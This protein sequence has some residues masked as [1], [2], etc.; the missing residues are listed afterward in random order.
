MLDAVRDDTLKVRELFAM[1]RPILTNAYAARPHVESYQGPKN[2]KMAAGSAAVNSFGAAYAVG[3]VY[4]FLLFSHATEF[5]D[6]SGRLH[7]VVLTAAAALIAA[8]SA[9]QLPAT[10][11]SKPG[12]CLTLFTMF[13]VVGIP[14]SA[15]KGNSLANF[16]NMWWKSYLSFFFVASLIF[17]V[18]QMRKS[19]FLLGASTFGIA[20]FSF[21]AMKVWSDGRI[22]VEYGSLGNSNDLAGALLVSLPFVLYVVVDKRR[23]ML[24][25]LAFVALIFVMLYL[26]FKT[27]SRSSVLALGFMALLVFFKTNAQNKFKILVVTGVMACIFPLV[28]GKVLMDRYK[29]MFS[30]EKTSEM[31]DDAASAVESTQARRQLMYNAVELTIRNPIFGVG[32]GNFRDQS[33][34]LEISKGRKPL[35]FTSHDIYLLVSA[36]TGVPGIALYLATMIVS[37]ATMIRIERAAKLTQELRELANMAFCIFMALVVFAACGIF[38]TNA[39]NVELPLLAALTAAL[40]RISKPVLAAAEVRRIE[41]FRQSIPVRPSKFASSAAAA[42]SVR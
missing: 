3:A 27:G 13:L 11:S 5:I 30:T 35:W 6:T 14:F 29:T 39:Y 7:L 23:A 34:N 40:D 2:L 33:A 21:K 38:S 26:V 42:L 4:L 19:L 22:S 16:L 10:L 24:I 25:R 28:A 17:T 1:Q 20:Y 9:G 8:F 31:T 41:Q 32:L 37:F 18:D 36:E 15:W 12:I